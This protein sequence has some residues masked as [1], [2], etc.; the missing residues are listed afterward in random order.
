MP[1]QGDLKSGHTD[2]DHPPGNGD[3]M[4]CPWDST[5]PLSVDSQAAKYVLTLSLE[6]QT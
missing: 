5:F 2:E 1:S 4:S 3:L 6:S